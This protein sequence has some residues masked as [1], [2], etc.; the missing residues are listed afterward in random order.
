MDAVQHTVVSSTTRA[1]DA[2]LSQ[3]GGSDLARVGTGSVW[4]RVAPAA[5]EA[6]GAPEPETVVGVDEGHVVVRD[7]REP[8]DAPLRERALDD[9]RD[10][11]RRVILR[12][13]RERLYEGEEG[14]SVQG[15]VMVVR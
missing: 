2:Q 1:M 7:P 9:L 5:P 13:A 11:A 4:V 3:L 15:V 6:P 14:V 10:R 12:D 8:V